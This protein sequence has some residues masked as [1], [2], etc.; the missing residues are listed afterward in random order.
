MKADQ[1]LQTVRA[2]DLERV[3]LYGNVQV[4][5]QAAAFL[6]EQGIETSFLSRS[7]RFRGRLAP[8]DS[9]NVFLRLAQYDRHRDEAFR[10]AVGRAIV[11][12]KIANS[13]AL[14]RRYGRN[15]PEIDLEATV[16]QLDAA[17][18]GVPPQASI[19]AL[20]GTEGQAAA[21]YFRAYGRLFR[22]ELQFTTRSRRP[23]RDPVNALLSLGYTL[24]TSE[25]AGALAAHGL[26]IYIGFLHS[27]EYG[28][29]SLALDLVEEFRQPVIDRF[30]LSLANRRVLKPED[31]E[32]RGAEGVF[33]SDAARPR[34]FAFYER[35][36]AT[37]F[38]DRRTGQPTSFRALLG[39]QARK[40]AAAVQSGQTYEPWAWGEYA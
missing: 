37:E 9:K 16:A 14:L 29:P 8:A 7:G 26:D 2:R 36:M 32:D 40:M 39:A 19:E 38:T 31:F 11:A 27:L 34:Y 21:A 18:P 1:E 3:V 20:M 30:T 33:L 6:L 28:R 35:M 25:A 22:Q 12:R 4:T 13:R 24:L 5:S 23:P 17:L 15:H 10:L